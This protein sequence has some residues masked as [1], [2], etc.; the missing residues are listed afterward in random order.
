MAL[1]APQQVLLRSTRSS[2]NA[3]KPATC[4]KL[5][6]CRAVGKDTQDTQE[7]GVRPVC[8]WWQGLQ[9]HYPSYTM[10]SNH[11][12]SHMPIDT[13]YVTCAALN[14]QGPSFLQRCATTLLAAATVA[15]PMTVSPVLV[16]GVV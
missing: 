9:V 13:V 15:M 4:R 1:Q 14:L 16:R 8:V 2:S 11:I 3:F 6:P 12:V 5:Q 10:H 7:V